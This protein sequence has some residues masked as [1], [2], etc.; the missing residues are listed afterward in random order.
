MGGRLTRKQR[1][2]SFWMTVGNIP[3]STVS[4]HLEYA[5]YS[6]PLRIVN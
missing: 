4:S 3:L 6:L 5:F 2:S 1:A